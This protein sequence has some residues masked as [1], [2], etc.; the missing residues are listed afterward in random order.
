MYKV[1]KM[2]NKY[3]GDESWKHTLRDDITGEIKPM[4]VKI[5]LVKDADIIELHNVTSIIIS[6]DDEVGW[7]TYTYISEIDQRI[8]TFRAVDYEWWTITEDCNDN[9]SY[10]D[11]DIK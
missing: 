11:G 7:T 8:K 9:K 2:G 10:S 3:G 5:R 6:V 4:L 1:E